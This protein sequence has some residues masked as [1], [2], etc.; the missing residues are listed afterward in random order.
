M[1]IWFCV[2]FGG[3]LGAV[4]RYGVMRLTS[5][6]FASGVF[7]WGIFIINILGSLVLGFLL[8]IV[9]PAAKIQPWWFFTSTGVLGGFTTFSTLSGDS[10]S[11]LNQGRSA[12]AAWNMFGSGI[13]GLL[14]VAA[15]WSLARFLVR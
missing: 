1:K 8:G 6:W 5:P 11:L 13:A 12:L 10:F 7:P 15:G 3:G 2:F 14:A 4:M 9:T